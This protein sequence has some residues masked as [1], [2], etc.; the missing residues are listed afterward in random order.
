M[1]IDS[2]VNYEISFSKEPHKDPRYQVWFRPIEVLSLAHLGNLICQG[3]W[4]PNLWRDGRRK[5]ENFIGSSFLTYDFDDG[6]TVKEV[7]KYCQGFGIAFVIGA[8]RHHQIPKKDKPACD[9]FRLVIP[10][11]GVVTSESDLRYTLKNKSSFFKVDPSCN[12]GGRLFFPCTKIL[13]IKTGGTI[14][15][16]KA[17]E[18]K[19]S[20][21]K[22]FR[23]QNRILPRWLSEMAANAMP[24]SGLG[25][26]RYSD[27][28]RNN[29]I[30]MLARHL[31][32]YALSDSEIMDICMKNPTEP[33]EDKA[34]VIRQGI[35]AGRK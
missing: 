15:W 13:E 24:P 14:S 27:Q 1:L 12:E 22:E 18:Y 32:S 34:Y 21:Y 4:S 8:T 16:E 11:S 35:K 3:V 5:K 30:F 23:I 6:M 19:P 33:E 20:R 9:R 7:S 31:A 17:P 29:F 25:G 2:L 10:F 26:G 28:G